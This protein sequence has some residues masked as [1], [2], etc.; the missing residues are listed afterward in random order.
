[1]RKQYKRPEMSVQE[2]EVCYVL[3]DSLVH[4]GL[5]NPGENGDIK[6]EHCGPLSY[7]P[8]LHKKAGLLHQEPG[9]VMCAMVRRSE[10]LVGLECQSRHTSE[11]AIEVKLCH[12]LTVASSVG[13]QYAILLI[14]VF[15][16][17][18]PALQTG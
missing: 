2:V 8:V 12:D 13:W 9:R 3:A 1:M 6:K 16:C 4:G 18:E 10:L 14:G 11:I 17:C 15:M 5:G 7:A